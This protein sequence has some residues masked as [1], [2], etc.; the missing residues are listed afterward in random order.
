MNK[1]TVKLT[2]LL[3]V[4]AALVVLSGCGGTKSIP[5]TVQSEPL[6][7]HV[8]YQVDSSLKGTSRD[9]I[10]LGKTPLDIKRNIRRKQLRKASAFRIKMMKDGFSDQVR[11]WNG[12]DIEA[13]LEEK[14]H[15]FWNPKLVPSN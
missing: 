5:M 13:E 9:W 2:Q 11:D 12:K 15:L 4:V 14:G 1:I 8:A 6:G 3:A 10:Y 7:A